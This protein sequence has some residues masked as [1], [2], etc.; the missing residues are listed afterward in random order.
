MLLVANLVGYVV[1]M[2]FTIRASVLLLA[3]CMFLYMALAPVIEAAEQTVLQR[4]VPYDKQGRVFGFAQA[5][6]VAAAPITAFLIGPIAEFGLIPYMEEGR[7]G[8]HFGWLLGDGDARGIALVFVAGSVIGLVA[9]LLALVSRPYRRL[10]RA[11]EEAP[12]PPTGGA[13]EPAT[14]S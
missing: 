12:P 5:V 9:T 8:V 11:Y 1:G 4:V 14:T 7:G 2:L 3:I 13:A 10:S 6:E